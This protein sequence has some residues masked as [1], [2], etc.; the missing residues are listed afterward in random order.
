MGK[1]RRPA[2]VRVKCPNGM[3]ADTE[4]ELVTFDEDGAE[5][6]HEFDV[7][8]VQLDITSGDR[9][10]LT[11]DVYDFDVTANGMRFAGP[12]PAAD[13]EAESESHGLERD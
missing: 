6:I 3:G 12:S 8:S 7:H 10:R 5:T 9:A 2:M 13:A 4:V 11:V 1:R